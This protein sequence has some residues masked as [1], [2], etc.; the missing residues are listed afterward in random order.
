MVTAIILFTFVTYRAAGRWLAGPFAGE[1]SRRSPV[2]ARIRGRLPDGV[3]GRDPRMS[4]QWHVYRVLRDTTPQ[5]YTTPLGALSMMVRNRDRMIFLTLMAFIFWIGF[6]LGK[7]CSKRCSSGRLQAAA[8]SRAASSD[9]EQRCGAT[10][11]ACRHP[12]LPSSRRRRGSNSA[13]STGCS[14]RPLP[15]SSA[16]FRLLG[17]SRSARRAAGVGGGER[18]RSLRGYGRVARRRGRPLPAVPRAPGEEE[19]GAAAAGRRARTPATFSPSVGCFRCHAI[20]GK[21]ETPPRPDAGRLDGRRPRGRS[22]G[23]GLPVGE[24]EGGID[25]RRQGA[26]VR[27]DHGRGST[28]VSQ[29]QLQD[30]VAYLTLRVTAEEVRMASR[31]TRAG[32]PRAP[33]YLSAPTASAALT[34]TLGVPP[35]LLAD[36]V[37]WLALASAPSPSRRA[38]SSGRRC[39]RAGAARRRPRH[40]RLRN[41]RRRPL[42]SRVGGSP[43]RPASRT[44]HGDSNL[45]L[46]LWPLLILLS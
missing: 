3:D 34:A 7:P 46:R 32:A 33:P 27:A 1:R 8:E 40:A 4:R 42:R 35:F 41:H 29:Q 37:W 23:Q 15:S 39:A 20:A 36:N 28:L 25:V 26:E 43:A 31:E 16:F 24:A 18:G 19:S 5:W 17:G 10:R 44:R 22:E 9:P 14:S 45:L 6:K 2:R 30:L 38:S 13:G 12:G 11:R 21:G